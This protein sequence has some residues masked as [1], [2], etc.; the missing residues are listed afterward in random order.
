[1]RVLFFAVPHNENKNA[2]K[3]YF[4]A[5]RITECAMYDVTTPWNTSATRTA[6]IMKHTISKTKDT[7]LARRMKLNN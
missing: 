4:P 2:G 3:R 1:M 5:T 6:L 7:V